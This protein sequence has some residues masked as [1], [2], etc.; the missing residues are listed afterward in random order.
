MLPGREQS[1][2]DGTHWPET[3]P[4]FCCHTATATFP[5]SHPHL[6]LQ[7]LGPSGCPTPPSAQGR[8]G[9]LTNQTPSTVM[10]MGNQ[11]LV[12]LVS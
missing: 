1:S 3:S 11:F 8:T 5:G 7:L 4:A 6:T 9:A 2:G 12:Q 10:V